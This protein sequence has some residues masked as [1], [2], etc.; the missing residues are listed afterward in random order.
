LA[1]PH[2]SEKIF[3]LI[4]NNLYIING[5]NMKKTDEKAWIVNEMK[6]MEKKRI[7]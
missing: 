3:L 6:T 1:E 5:R 4:Y 7:F 2:F